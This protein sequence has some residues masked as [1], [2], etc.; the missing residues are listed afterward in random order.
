MALVQED[1]YFDRIFGEIL[2]RAEKDREQ[3]D[4]VQTAPPNYR[5]E[6]PPERE[7]E[8]MERMFLVFYVKKYLELKEENNKLKE[9]LL[10]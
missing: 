7:E 9:R 1:N 8:I 10:S 6:L 5:V 4:F 3:W 2:E